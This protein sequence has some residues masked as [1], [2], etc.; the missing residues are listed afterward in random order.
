MQ[1][2]NILNYPD[3]F[4]PK[5]S[6]SQKPYQTYMIKIIYDGKG[7]SISWQDES[8]SKT[9]E[10]VQLRELFKNIED[11]IASKEEYKKMPEANK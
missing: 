1:K 10:S 6:I 11:I 9:A 5:S 2:I 7:K 4:I 3:T 8:V